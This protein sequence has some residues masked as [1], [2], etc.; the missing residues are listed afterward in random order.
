MKEM[1]GGRAMTEEEVKEATVQTAVQT[2]VLAM[3]A[4]L[5]KSPLNTIKLKAAFQTDRWRHALAT[6]QAHARTMEA[7]QGGNVTSEEVVNLAN[8]EH[9][10]IREEIAALNELKAQ[11]DQA[12]EGSGVNRGSLDAQIASLSAY[13]GKARGFAFAFAMKARG[14]S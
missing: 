3:T 14:A 9:A 13:Q 5:L 2:V 11:G 7:R 10:Q 12:L 1:M 6:N 8:Q 4:R